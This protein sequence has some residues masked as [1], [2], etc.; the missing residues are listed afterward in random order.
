MSDV[1]EKQFVKAVSIV[2]SLPREGPIQPSQ[3]ERLYFYSFHQQATI[4]DVNVP[5]PGMLD[6]EGKAKWDEWKIREGT[7]K[8]DAQAKY[9]RKLIEILE[10]TDCDEAR[11][12]L[13]EIQQAG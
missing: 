4:G 13:A 7:T 10:A 3:A 11:E 1:S 5:R 2:Q 8:E 9:V 12:K 6:F